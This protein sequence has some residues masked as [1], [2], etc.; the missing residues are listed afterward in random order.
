MKKSQIEPGLSPE[1][2]ELLDSYDHD[3]WRSVN[4]LQEARQ[5]YQAYA[6]AA[7]EADGIISIMLPAKDLRVVRQKAAEAGVSHQALIA[8]IVH[9][10]A[11][12]QQ[13]RSLAG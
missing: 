10:F 3:E 6:S 1:E 4:H 7:L 12:E 2:Q 9:Q 5:Q 11:V 13:T 8:R